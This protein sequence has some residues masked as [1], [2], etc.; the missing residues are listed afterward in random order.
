MKPTIY[1]A[2]SWRNPDYEGVLHMLKLAGYDVYDFKNPES[3]YHWSEISP[4]W[5]SWGGRE[6]REALQHPLTQRAYE[7]DLQAVKDRDVLV[8]MTPCG[9]SAHSEMAY[10]KGIGKRV[11]IFYNERYPSPE[12]LHNLAD[13]IVITE[14]ELLAKLADWSTP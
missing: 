9:S 11:I 4:E 12:V 2:T 6:L 8:M 13:S 10:A 5:K 1:L 14:G 3:E 7:H